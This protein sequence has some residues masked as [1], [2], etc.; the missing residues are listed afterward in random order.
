MSLFNLANSMNNIVYSKCNTKIKLNFK[1]VWSI[2]ES[3]KMLYREFS[4]YANFITANFI[5]YCDFSKV[6][7]YIA[8]AIFLGQIFHYCDFYNWPRIEKVAVMK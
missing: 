5:T 7:K 2:Q 3:E 1:Y 4:P 6:F 8:N